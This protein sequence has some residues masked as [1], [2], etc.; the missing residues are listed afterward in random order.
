MLTTYWFKMTTNEA[1]RYLG[2]KMEKLQIGSIFI[3]QESY[4]RT[5]LKGYNM[6]DAN[7]VTVPAHKNHQMSAMIHPD[8][9]QST[10]TPY[11]EALGS[12]RYL[13]IATRPDI[14]CAAN[15]ASQYLGQRT[16]RRSIEMH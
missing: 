15:T 10:N 6:D 7:P 3:Y 11:R 16:Q 5:L 1:N 9:N 2:L 14:T 8:G 13:S 4:A 12:L